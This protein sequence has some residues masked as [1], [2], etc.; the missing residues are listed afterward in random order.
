MPKDAIGWQGMTPD[1]FHA[2]KPFILHS[3]CPRMTGDDRKW[4]RTFCHMLNLHIANKFCWDDMGWRLPMGRQGMT[5]DDMGWHQTCFMQTNCPGMTGDDREWHH[6]FCCTFNL[7]FANKL[8]WDD[9]GWHGMTWDVTWPCVLDHVCYKK[10]AL[11]QKHL[12]KYDMG[13]PRMTQEDCGPIS[14]Q[15]L[16][17][18]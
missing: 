12:L 11:W 5:G 8:P 6:T 9:M 17:L 3:Y 1:M 4:H 18:I 13:W 10:P 15:I 2:E 14:C 7:H 16:S